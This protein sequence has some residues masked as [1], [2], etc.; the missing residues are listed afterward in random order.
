MGELPRKVAAAR[1][2][3][4]YHGQ[5]CDIAGHGQKRY[6]SNGSCYACCRIRDAKAVTKRQ[7]TIARNRATGFSWPVF[8]IGNPERV[9]GSGG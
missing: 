4:F 2:A 9:R 3:T 6:T 1:G 8:I 5:T 7:L